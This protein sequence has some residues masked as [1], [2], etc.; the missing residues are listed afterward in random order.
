MNASG[1]I[2]SIVE[3]CEKLGVTVKLHDFDLEFVGQYDHDKRLIRINEPNAENA[4][5]TLAHELGH[6]VGYL[7]HGSERNRSKS[8][9]HRERQAYVYGWKILKWF[10]ADTIISRERWIEDCRAAHKAFLKLGGE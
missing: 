1:H 5:A 2:Y 3:F 7:I 4:L 8:Q 9:V 6:Y 10:G